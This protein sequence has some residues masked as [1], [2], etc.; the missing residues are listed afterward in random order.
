MK[1][2]VRALKED[3]IQKK[4]KKMKLSRLINYLCHSKKYTRSKIAVY[5]KHLKFKEK[6]V[7]LT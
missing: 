3:T 1:T 6:G 5:H 7:N 2:S 4:K